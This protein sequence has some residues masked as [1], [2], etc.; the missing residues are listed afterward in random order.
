[1]V[2]NFFQH[3]WSKKKLKDDSMQKF[4]IFM[5]DWIQILTVIFLRNT[6]FS[7]KNNGQN[8]NCIEGMGKFSK[9]KLNERIKAKQMIKN[10]PKIEIIFTL[11]NFNCCLDYYWS[12][13]WKFPQ[14]F[15]WKLLDFFDTFDSMEEILQNNI[16]NENPSFSNTKL[17]LEITWLFRRKF[18]NLPPLNS[19]F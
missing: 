1:L 18:N 13:C 15:V 17:Y 9:Q 10:K 16:F 8:L 19:K 6:W 4:L 5:N 11:F 12:M 14:N 7:K 2:G 3:H